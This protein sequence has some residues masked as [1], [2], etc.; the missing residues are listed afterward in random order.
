MWSTP[1]PSAGAA[2]GVVTGG[3]EGIDGIGVGAGI[4][5]SVAEGPAAPSSAP[6][7]KTCLQRLHRTWTP[8][9]FI[10]SS[11]IRNR[12]VHS[13]QAAITSGGACSRGVA[14]RVN[15][16]ASD[17]PAGGPS[18]SGPLT[19]RVKS[20]EDAAVPGK[21]IKRYTNRKLYDTA[22]S[23]YVTLDEIADMVKAGEDVQIVD[24]KTGDDLSSVTLAQIVYEEEKKQ[25]SIL[26]LSALRQIIRSGGDLFQRRS[27][28]LPDGVDAGAASDD[29][30]ADGQAANGDSPMTAFLG[31]SQ[32]AFE[33]LQRRIDE[34]VHKVIETMTQLPA[35][36]S[37]VHTL[38]E[39]IKEL[40]ARIEELEGGK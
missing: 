5:V 9:G 27:T 35:V 10:L 28:P 26:P 16:C 30:S 3:M 23:C 15:H 14:K 37:E 38:R 13:G 17:E 39:R 20:P 22:R 24:N 18:P 19:P 21:V 4:G 11:G 40:E 2:P 31:R 29:G 12:A 8:P 6:A 7:V 1:K 32:E 25:K 34:R 36:Q 33:D